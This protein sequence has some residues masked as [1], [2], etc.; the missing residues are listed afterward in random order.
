M[1][2]RHHGT[3]REVRMSQ[4]DPRKLILRPFVDAGA[5]IVREDGSDFDIVPVSLF[6][7]VDGGAVFRV[8]RNG[9]YFDKKG[10]Y[11]GPEAN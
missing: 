2:T 5:P 7:L 8:G 4:H 3:T 11:D 1:A 10:A 6:R 9:Y